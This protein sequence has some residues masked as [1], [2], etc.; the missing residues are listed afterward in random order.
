MVI[1]PPLPLPT[2]LALITPPLMIVTAP[3]GG[4]P[5]GGGGGPPGGPPGGGGGGG[6]GPPEGGSMDIVPPL[7]LVPSGATLSDAG[8]N[9]RP[10]TPISTDPPFPDDDPAEPP[11]AEMTKSPV[12]DP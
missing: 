9:V 7:P 8:S 10:G 3:P 5:G 6:G 12:P 2:P 11:V 4:P 1:E